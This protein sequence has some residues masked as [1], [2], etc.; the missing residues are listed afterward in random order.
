LENQQASQ[1]EEQALALKAAK[2]ETDGEG[3]QPY[4]VL[5]NYGQAGKIPLQLSVT[6][7][8]PLTSRQ[9]QGD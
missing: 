3:K 8:S 4:Y 5:Q 9:N 7:F 6:L 2:I 1:N